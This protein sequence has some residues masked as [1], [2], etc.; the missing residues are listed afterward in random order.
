MFFAP[1]VT[2]WFQ[3]LNKV[4]MTN[5]LK[6]T[7]IRVGLDQFVSAPVVLSCE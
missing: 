2:T 5:K 3:V 7:A 6:G 4:P 1:A